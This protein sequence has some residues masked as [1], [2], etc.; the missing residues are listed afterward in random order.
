MSDELGSVTDELLEDVDDDSIPEELLDDADEEDDEMGPAGDFGIK[1]GIPVGLVAAYLLF[2]SPL[3]VLSLSPAAN[4]LFVTHSDSAVPLFYVAGTTLP[5]A[6]VAALY[7]SMAADD[8]YDGYRHDIALGT[9]VAPA[10]AIVLGAGALL[11]EPV[12]NDVLAGNLA[13]AM[14]F[15][16]IEIIV[17]GILLASSIGFIVVFVFFALYLGIPSYLGVY[18]GS[19]I[20]KFARTESP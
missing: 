15:L 12:A 6:F 14:L 8:L 9:I 16:V 20:G 5:I 13:D 18:V 7:Y 1:A 19:F 10:G 4:D 2:F 11:L 17:L 3:R